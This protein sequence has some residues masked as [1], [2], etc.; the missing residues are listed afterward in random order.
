MFQPSTSST[1]G[2]PAVWGKKRKCTKPQWCHT[3]ICLL[4]VDDCVVPTFVA[5]GKLAIAE[6]GEKKVDFPPGKS[7]KVFIDSIESEFPKLK[8]GGGFEVVRADGKNLRLIPSP[9]G[10]YTVEYMRGILN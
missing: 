3:F 10:G 2:R 8:D 1:S 5:K 6:L 9:P 7:C 4:K